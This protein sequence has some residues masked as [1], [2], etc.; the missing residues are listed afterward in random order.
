[1]S[2]ESGEGPK[3]FI[4]EGWKERVEAEK[5]AAAAKQAEEKTTAAPPQQP[6]PAQPTAT[7]ASEAPEKSTA[8]PGAQPPAASLSFLIT[9]LATQAMMC[10]GQLP[11][12]ATGQAETRLPEAKH[13]IDML[14]VLEEK[15]AGN[16]TSEES[17][18]LD[19]FLHELRMA[20]V[21]LQS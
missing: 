7:P 6:S 12:P 8:R 18:L 2:S 9:T 10:L 21:M 13:F 11:N 17:V 4:D 5:H 19:G 16:R 3:I 1:M 15:T 14:E 20:Y